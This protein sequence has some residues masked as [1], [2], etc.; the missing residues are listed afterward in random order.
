[1]ENDLAEGLRPGLKIRMIWRPAGFHVGLKL[2][3]LLEAA[4][5][6]LAG[7]VAPAIST[8][9]CGRSRSH[10]WMQRGSEI[11]GT[12]LKSVILT[13][14]PD[15]LRPR[16]PRATGGRERWRPFPK[17]PGNL[18]GRFVRARIEGL[19]FL[20]RGHREPET[21]PRKFRCI[22]VQR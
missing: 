21:Y 16:L 14:T 6:K 20:Q 2:D 15:P 18:G 4:P 22:G 17:S 13:S 10:R 5:T 11:L 19:R 9:V 1:M 3:Q 8:N 7:R 12:H